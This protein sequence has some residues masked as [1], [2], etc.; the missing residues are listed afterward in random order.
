M[1]KMT[2]EEVQSVELS[3]L[4]HVAGFCEAHALTYYLAYGTL[5][6]AVRHGGFIPWDDDADI[7][8]PREDYDRFVA[9]FSDDDR[10]FLVRPFQKEFGFAWAKVVDKRTSYEN[11]KFCMPDSYGLSLDV[12][13]L[14]SDRG[15]FWYGIAHQMR[16]QRRIK[17]R[18]PTE[19][20]DASSFK[21]F[22]KSIAKKIIPEL[23][24]D[25]RGLGFVRGKNI[26]SDRCVNYLSRYSY[27]RES[28]PIEWF[29]EGK[30]M[31]FE[32]SHQYRVPNEPERILDVV[33]GEN[34]RVPEVS[35]HADVTV[36]W[37]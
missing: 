2:L 24:V 28:K 14:D 19:S 12:F 7:L 1:E 33:Y 18:T 21:R 36:Y 35:N 31:P 23:F 22:A 9:E 34:W 15:P 17:W 4:D 25:E 16:K 26:A 29:G 3:L 37:R 6:G 11:T 20:A 10:Y 13:P 32:G 27:G 8:M 5:L 30:M